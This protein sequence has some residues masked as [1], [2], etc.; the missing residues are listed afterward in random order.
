MGKSRHR[1]PKEPVRLIENTD[2]L[3]LIEED[4]QLMLLEKFTAQT[5][6]S[7]PD[8]RPMGPS[9]QDMTVHSGKSLA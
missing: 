9:M 8:P 1:K 7:S 2:L 4:L 3:E 6:S 5:V